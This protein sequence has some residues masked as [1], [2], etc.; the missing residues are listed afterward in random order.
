MIDLATSAVAAAT[1]VAALLAV[2]FRLAHRAAVT[3]FG[4]FSWAISFAIAVVPP[5]AVVSLRIPTA[6]GII[7]VHL[8]LLAGLAPVQNVAVA[9]AL[10]GESIA[11]INR[12]I[13]AA[14]QAVLARVTLP[15]HTTAAIGTTALAVAIGGTVAAD[16]QTIIGERFTVRLNFALKVA[17]T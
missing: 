4:E 3:I 11:G 13:T 15:T 16:C 10:K 8:F 14:V 2:T 12:R 6:S 9:T 1:V 5:L 17:Q 7:A